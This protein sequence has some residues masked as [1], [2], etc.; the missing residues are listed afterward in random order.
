MVVRTLQ[1]IKAFNS[2]GEIV[3][4]PQ[5]I[6]ISVSQDKGNL[7]INLEL[8]EPVEICQLGRKQSFYVP[9]HEMVKECLH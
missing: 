9:E 6:Y 8:A 4:I 5:G 7:L 2:R 1:R 3:E